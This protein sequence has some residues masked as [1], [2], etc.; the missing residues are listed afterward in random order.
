MEAEETVANILTSDNAKP[1]FA[2]LTHDGGLSILAHPASA[3][4]W[5]DTEVV[6]PVM[7]HIIHRPGDFWLFDYSWWCT[8]FISFGG[9]S[10][11]LLFEVVES[12][13]SIQPNVLQTLVF[14]T[15]CCCITPVEMP[16]IID[17]NVNHLPKYAQ[18]TPGGTLLEC[19]TGQSSYQPNPLLPCEVFHCRHFNY[20]NGQ[21]HSNECLDFRGISVDAASSELTRIQVRLVS[22]DLKEKYVTG[23]GSLSGAVKQL[24]EAVDRCSNYWKRKKLSV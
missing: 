3:F 7:S 10:P 22:K 17:S 13:D 24:G 8:V 11:F 16:C 20:T 23:V 2:L 1:H 6:N 4:Y 18:V 5:Q 19:D 12:F 9:P 15:R 14:L 21:I